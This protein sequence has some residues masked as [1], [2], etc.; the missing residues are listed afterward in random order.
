MTDVATRNEAH[1]TRV[2]VTGGSGFIGTNVVDFYLD[3]GVEVLS[4]DH[5]PPRRREHAPVWQQVELLDREAVRR[6]VQTFA[7]THLLH[8]AARTDLVGRDLGDYAANTL[9]VE[10]LIGA[11]SGV[12][13]LKRII[14][15]S[16]RMVCE[17][18]YQP[19]ND[20]DYCPTTVYGE[21]KVETERIVRAEAGDL[22]WTIVRPS[23]IWGPW[24]DAPYKDFFLSIARG[25]YFHL[26]R[27]RVHKSFG[28]VGNSVYQLH[29]LLLAPLHRV[30][31]K[32]LYLADYP[33][34]EVRDWAERIRDEIGARPI[35]A[36]PYP[37]FKAAAVTG[38][39]LRRFGWQRVP[40]TSFR[41]KNLLTEM[42]YDLDPLEGIVGPL[43]HS[44]DE[45]TARTVAWLREQG[46]IG[47]PE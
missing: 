12:T 16:T 38:D 30:V 11:L 22:P 36:A 17:I 37:V 46:E 24:F 32:T 45:G 18:G 9:G 34:L 42:V 6:A 14:F 31:G 13:S 7:P 15:A 40:L 27:R 5:S 35:R 1:I 2:L 26:G 20:S 10:N 29:R 47:K 25:R 23:S 33:A 21:S 41:L 28:F 8:M 19:R 3:A 4:I 43:P 39:L 44:L